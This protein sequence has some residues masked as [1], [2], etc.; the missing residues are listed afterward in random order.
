[1]SSIAVTEEKVLDLLRK[2]YFD[3]Y[4]DLFPGYSRPETEDECVF[5]S[6]TDAYLEID[7]ILDLFN[8]IENPVNLFRT[9]SC[10][11][12]DD[13]DLDR[14]GDCWSFNERS[15]I[16]FSKNNLRGSIFLIRCRTE[17]NNIDWISTISLYLEF[18][19]ESFSDAE[20]EIRI[21]NQSELIDVC[22]MKKIR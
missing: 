9:V 6:K 7:R 8:S 4:Y 20:D 12:I 19:G 5:D 14:P 18:S 11:S 13:I 21:L 10:D 22:C 16:Q 3:S 1:M 2:R 17:K 15:A